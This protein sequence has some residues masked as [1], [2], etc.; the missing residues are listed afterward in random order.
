MRGIIPWDAEEDP[1]V[2]DNVVVVSFM[3]QTA[4]H[5]PAMRPCP[6]GFKLHCSDLR[7]QLYNR[8]IGNT[9]VFINR[10]P[11]GLSGVGGRIWTSIALQNFSGTVQQVG[12]TH[13]G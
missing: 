4:S 6:K 1:S 10:P 3:A 2:A 7:F 9:F 12:P 13:V 5:Q 11:V 8:N